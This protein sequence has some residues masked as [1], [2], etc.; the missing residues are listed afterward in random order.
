MLLRGIMSPLL[1]L[2]QAASREEGCTAL[3]RA[4]ALPG[5]GRD[6]Q[7]QV[8][9]GFTAGWGPPSYKLVYKPL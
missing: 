6:L 9:W 5:E 7:K 3:H 8:D 1:K 4:S 2:P